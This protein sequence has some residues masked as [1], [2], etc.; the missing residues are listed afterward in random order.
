MTDATP[1]VTFIPTQSINSDF[2]ATCEKV[3][4]SGNFQF[5]FVLYNEE[6]HIGQ[7]VVSPDL[8]SLTPR[9]NE[10]QSC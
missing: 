5:A 7:S 8:F 2:N 6:L 9:P 3:P 10:G 1:K 4:I